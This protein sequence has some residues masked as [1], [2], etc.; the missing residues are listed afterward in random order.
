[1][2]VMFQVHKNK[3]AKDAQSLNPSGSLQALTRKPVTYSSAKF[4]SFINKCSTSASP[5]I[6]ASE[7]EQKANPRSRS[8]KLRVLYKVSD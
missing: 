3:Y 6:I 4:Y 2:A 8:A 7:Q 1:M 5:Q